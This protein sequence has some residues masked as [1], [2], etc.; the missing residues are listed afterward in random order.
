MLKS[1]FKKIIIFFDVRATSIWSRELS[2]MV[3]W[4]AL[5]E[6]LMPSK[7]RLSTITE[8]SLLYIDVARTSKKTPPS[9]TFDY[10]NIRVPLAF[11]WLILHPVTA[12]HWSSIRLRH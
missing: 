12:F 4:L 9:E 2:V 10:F 7:I 8:S 11:D 5:R 1:T 6:F 3:L